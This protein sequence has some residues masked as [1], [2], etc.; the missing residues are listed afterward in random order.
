MRFYLLFANFVKLGVEIIYATSFV[1]FRTRKAILYVRAPVKFCLYF[2][3]IY[4]R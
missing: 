2:V 1:K 4:P 3:R